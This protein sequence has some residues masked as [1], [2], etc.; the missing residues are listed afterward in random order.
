MFKNISDCRYYINYG[1]CGNAHKVTFIKR[2]LY[3]RCNLR[4]A[5][6]AR[7][8]FWSGSYLAGSCNLSSWREQQ[9]DNCSSSCTGLSR[10]LL[11]SP[12]RTSVW[13]DVWTARN[14][15]APA[16]QT[17]GSCVHWRLSNPRGVL[18]G[19]RQVWSCLWRAE[20]G[21]NTALSVLQ[22]PHTAGSQRKIH[23]T[24]QL[25]TTKNIAIIKSSSS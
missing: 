17:E 9:W 18:T 21:R 11:L 25:S 15:P 10:T 3:Q 16:S 2:F 1:Q 13:S 19:L 7:D 8:M 4:K 23:G 24:L 12:V 5:S 6:F 14:N 22:C 20:R